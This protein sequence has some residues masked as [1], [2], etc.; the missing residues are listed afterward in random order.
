MCVRM[1]T[2]Q[3]IIDFFHRAVLLQYA[4]VLQRNGISRLWRHAAAP[5]ER[6][7]VRHFVRGY[8]VF[9]LTVRDMESVTFSFFLF[10]PIRCN[11]WRGLVRGSLF[12]GIW[13][14]CSRFV[15]WDGDPFQSQFFFEQ[16]EL[17]AKLL[18]YFLWSNKSNI[19]QSRISITNFENLQ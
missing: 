2:N 15:T 18:D 19:N 8:L 4:H 16:I 12:V 9:L 3:I 13:C 11:L 5:M 1:Y 6:P 14:F 10:F 17:P 7:R